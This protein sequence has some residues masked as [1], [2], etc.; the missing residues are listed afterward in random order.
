MYTNNRP[1]VAVFSWAIQWSI[2][3]LLQQFK[4]SDTTV[5]YDNNVFGSTWSCVL[6][7]LTKC[8]ATI[9]ISL[10]ILQV[11]ECKWK[12]WATT[13][14]GSTTYMYMYMVTWSSIMHIVLRGKISWRTSRKFIQ[15][16]E[17]LVLVEKAFLFSLSLILIVS[18]STRRRNG[19]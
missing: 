15:W 17:L 4:F 14:I 9:Q 2:E 1:D 7:W 19:E 10:G 12:Y 18:W 11:L 6:H 3:S 5:K 13:E 16:A 8:Q